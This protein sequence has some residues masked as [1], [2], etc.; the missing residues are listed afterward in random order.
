M[1][2]LDGIVLQP[3]QGNSYWM[4]GDLHT[5]KAVSEETDGRYTLFEL[6][7]QPQHG[8]PLHVQSR[9]AE[10]FFIEAGEVEFQLDDRTVVAT[11][12][13]FLHSPLGQLHKFTNVSSQPAKMLCWAIPAG[14]EKFF[15]AAGTKVEDLNAPP[16]PVTPADLEK[17]MKLAPQ[18][19]ITILPPP[20]SAQ[21][22]DS[23]N[24]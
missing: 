4:L 12:G 7:L 19:G 1:T 15:A 3:D 21:L 5:F 17:V 9:E 16:P 20:D 23:V 13:M 8:T 6:V 22:S 10:A 2:R 14:I 18:Y 11:P 24:F